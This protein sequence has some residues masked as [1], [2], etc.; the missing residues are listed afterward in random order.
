MITI[1]NRDERGAVNM[2]WLNSKHSFSFGHYYDPAHMG[3][4]ALRVINDD[5]VI[6][7][8]G[9]PTH[10]HADMEI[11]SYVLD[12]ALEHKDTL[13]TSSVIRPGDVQRMSAG[14]GIRHSE[15]NASKKDPVHFLQI[16]ILP[17]EE[18]M[19]P[20]YE[21]KAFEREEKQGRLRLVGSQDGRDGSV[22]IH[23]D[24]DLYATLLDEGDSV[25]HELRP[26]RHAWVQVARGQV[27]LNGEIL[28]E[29]DGAAISKEESL[30][31]DGVVSAEVL[32]FD[33]A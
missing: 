31:L 19:V 1:R 16:W 25:T 8:A 9:F 14:S 24:V 30:T 33:L 18:G 12:G 21:Q 15:Y 10:G 23:Q 11:V 6:P 7:G 13:G 3:F 4:R 27:R 2:G 20:G 17:N 5:R 22:V 29:G 26:G 32:L 28:K